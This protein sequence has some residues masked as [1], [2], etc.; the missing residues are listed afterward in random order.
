MILAVLF[1]V[2]TFTITMAV[3]TPYT[4]NQH[5]YPFSKTMIF[6]YIDTVPIKRRKIFIVEQDNT[7][8]LLSKKELNRSI[9]SGLWF[10]LKSIKKTNRDTQPNHDILT[11][12]KN[13]Q[14]PFDQLNNFPSFKFIKQISF[15]NCFWATSK[16]YLSNPKKPDYCDVILQKTF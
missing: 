14:A 7:K 2:S 9:Q 12:I 16:K 5:F 4:K 11:K 10:M 15:E 13:N 6:A 1:T 8:R 3:L